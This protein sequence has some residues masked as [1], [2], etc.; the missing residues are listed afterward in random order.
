MIMQ[1]FNIDLKEASL[2]LKMPPFTV[3]RCI[4]YAARPNGGLKLLCQDRAGETYFRQADLDAL[5]ADWGKPWVEDKK[6]RRPPLPAYFED[7]LRL[8]TFFRCGLCGS[9]YATEFAHIDPWEDCLNH[10]PWNLLSLCPTC[11]TGYDKEKRISRE[12]VVRAK[13]RAQEVLMEELQSFGLGLK[14][15]DRLKAV[16]VPIQGTIA[17]GIDIL[18]SILIPG[19]NSLNLRK[20]RV[21]ALLDKLEG[22]DHVAVVASSTL[23]R[24]VE[25]TMINLS[26]SRV[27]KPFWDE[28]AL[29]VYE[30][31]LFPDMFI[32]LTEIGKD[33]VQYLYDNAER[34]VESQKY[35]S[36]NEEDPARLIVALAT[37]CQDFSHFLDNRDRI[38]NMDLDDFVV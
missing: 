16:R 10:H 15:L 3:L 32:D 34:Y 6:S 12:E 17:T 24:L 20:S 30:R 13:H 31:G 2:H 23:L 4:R 8:E 28:F 36:M 7:A 14:C 38:N 9:P 5:L 11:H 1:D 35:P 37:H 26:L 18:I 33:L 19:C 25:T 29:W 22:N 27:C 21:V